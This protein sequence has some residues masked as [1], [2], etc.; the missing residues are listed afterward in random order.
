MEKLG[1]L[2]R[3]DEWDLIVVDTP[4]S[5]STL[6]FLAAPQRLSRFL[7]GRLIRLLTAPTR[8]SSRAYLRVVNAGFGMFTGVVAKGLL[9]DYV[10]SVDLVGRDERQDTR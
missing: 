4:P 2:R 1:Q 3:A 8:A 7:D 6:D 9:R 10:R 5:R